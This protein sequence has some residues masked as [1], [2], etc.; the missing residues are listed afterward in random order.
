M[1]N[2]SKLN[3]KEQMAIELRYLGNTLEEVAEKTDTLINTVNGWFR[4]GGKLHIPYIE[5][6]E[7]MNK[8]RQKDFEDKISVFDDEFFILTTNIVRQLGKSLQKRKVPLVNKKGE[9]IADENGNPKLVE[10]D[11][12]SEFNVSDLKT[13]WQMQRIMKGLPINYEKKDVEQINF[14]ADLVIKKL[15][16]TDEDFED[17]KLTETTEKIRNYFESQ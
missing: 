4:S 3:L 1:E 5:Y 15:G 10:I 6:V 8:K 12:V 9:V 11:P 17:D 14:E 13:V 7:S 16:L 2:T